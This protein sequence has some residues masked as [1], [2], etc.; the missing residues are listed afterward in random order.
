MCE[1]P[2]SNVSIKEKSQ[3]KTKKNFPMHVIY[4]ATRKLKHL[5]RREQGDAVGAVEAHAR[6]RGAVAA[7]SPQQ[8]RAAVRLVKQPQLHKG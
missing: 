6:G 7:A 2:Y 1:L 4:A 3:R 5:P 8:A